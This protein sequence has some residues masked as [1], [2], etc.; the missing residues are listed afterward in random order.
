MADTG[1]KVENMW[2]ENSGFEHS[3]GDLLPR[4]AIVNPNPFYIA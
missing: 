4:S 3:G 2:V 1:D